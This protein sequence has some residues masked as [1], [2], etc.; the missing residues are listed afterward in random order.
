MLDDYNTCNPIKDAETISIRLFNYYWSS[1]A[2]DV[3]MDYL[4]ATTSLPASS[5]GVYFSGSSYTALSSNVIFNHDFY[6]EML[7]RPDPDSSS[8]TLFSKYSGEAILTL[9]LNESSVLYLSLRMYNTSSKTTEFQSVVSTTLSPGEWH[10]IAVVVSYLEG[11][12]S[13]SFYDKYSLLSYSN[14]PDSYFIDETDNIASN[15]VIGSRYDGNQYLAFYRGFIVS[16][17]SK[18]TAEY[19]KPQDRVLREI[20]RDCNRDEYF[21]EKCKKC[22]EECKNGCFNEKECKI[23]G[24]KCRRMNENGVCEECEKLAEMKEG[25][26]KCVEHAEYESDQGCRCL[27]GYKFTQNTCIKED[28]KISALKKL[29][30]SLI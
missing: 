15:L 26:C 19:L 14:L 24:N 2:N 4:E 27:D 25:E 16:I 8:R 18:N 28:S 13:I 5:S 7:I 1:S 11:G 23:Y 3:S 17:V 10:K 21:D 12:T 29:L 30:D 20:G 6:V 9:G 22:K